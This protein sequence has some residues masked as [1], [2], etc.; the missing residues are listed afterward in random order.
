MYLLPDLRANDYEVVPEIVRLSRHVFGQGSYNQQRHAAV[1]QRAFHRAQVQDQSGPAE[2]ADRPI[3]VSP[4]KRRELPV[5]P[6]FSDD[7][8][9]HI[10]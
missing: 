3:T 4:N 1:S 9:A 10:P 5:L 8:N 7:R 6:R 2:K